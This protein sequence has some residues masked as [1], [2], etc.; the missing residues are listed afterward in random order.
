MK[1]P[2]V[3]SKEFLELCA[4]EKRGEIVIYGMAWYGNGRYIVDWKET[5]KEQLTNKDE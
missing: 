2:S 4:R 1:K 3:S 5:N